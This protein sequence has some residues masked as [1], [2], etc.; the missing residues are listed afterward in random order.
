VDSN[1]DER[2][3]RRIMD[4]LEQYNM[5]KTPTHSRS[6]GHDAREVALKENIDLLNTP[7]FEAFARVSGVKIFKDKS[8]KLNY[9]DEHE[10]VEFYCTIDA[11]NKLLESIK[12][13]RSRV[14]KY[15]NNDL[16]KIQLK[17]QK[18]GQQR[19]TRKHKSSIIGGARKTRTNR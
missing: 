10:P 14:K 18:G 17:F 11:F 7:P 2:K 15:E 9:Q 16:D 3:A 13:I 5:D 1:S 4:Q 19:I 12:S 6:D 8:N